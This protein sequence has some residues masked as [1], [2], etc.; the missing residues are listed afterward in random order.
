MVTLTS[1]IA[2]D[3]INSTGKAMTNAEKILSVM[4]QGKDYSR[5]ELLELTGLPINVVSSRVN[6][7]LK[8]D[9]LETTRHR[10][11]S[12]TGHLI[13][14]VCLKVQKGGV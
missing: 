7:L 2:Y 10:P 13:N 9:Q 8:T 14:A 6:Y 3:F 4:S 11:C 12:V 5:M 1:R